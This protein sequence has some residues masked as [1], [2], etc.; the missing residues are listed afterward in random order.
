MKQLI[1]VE[2]NT[3]TWSKIKS[4]KTHLLSKGKYHRTADLQQDIY[5]FGQIQTIQTIG[6]SYSDTSPYKASECSLIKCIQC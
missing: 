1:H 2:W 5:L 3:L 4:E 6:Q